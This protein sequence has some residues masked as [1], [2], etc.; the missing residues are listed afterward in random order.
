MSKKQMF[1]RVVLGS[2]S[3][4]GI[5]A[6]SIHA[7]YPRPIHGE[8]MTH[9]DF[10]RN[11]GSSRAKPVRFLLDE[12]RKT[13]YVPWHWGAN[14]S[15]MQAD[16][17]CNEQVATVTPLWNETYGEYDSIETNF[18]SRETAWVQA[19]I[20]ACNSAEAFMNAGYHKQNVNRLLEP[21]SWIDVL[22][23][24]TNW[25]NFFNLRDH[26]DAEPHI[27]DLAIMIKKA[28]AGYLPQKLGRGEWH[29]PYVGEADHYALDNADDDTLRIID[30]LGCDHQELL[31][32]LSAARCARISYK[33]HSGEALISR[34][35]ALCQQLIGN[36]AIHASPFEHQATP[37]KR[38]YT[39]VYNKEGQCGFKRDWEKPELHRNL[40]GW[41]Q[42]RALLPG[43]Y[44]KD[45]WDV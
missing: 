25:A 33:P 16:L 34:D 4:E 44:V 28:M 2:T 15:G 3:P 1:A 32:M 27:R 14:Q 12:V 21:F 6:W 18:E 10:S 9:K 20:N 5:T 43:E 19:S 45:V 29:M 37:D 8:M 30:D 41:I 7:R 38:S 24:S 42:N 36:G 31:N 22:I 11:A 23:T 40:T 17:E 39:P 35:L 26:P 13:P